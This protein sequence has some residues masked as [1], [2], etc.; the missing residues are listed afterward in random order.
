MWEW[1]NQNKFNC[2]TT[3]LSRRLILIKTRWF[4]GLPAALAALLCPVLFLKLV[5][6]E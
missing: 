3:S 1:E 5:G 6:E 4:S 2:S